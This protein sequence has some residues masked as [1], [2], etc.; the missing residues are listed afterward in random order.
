MGLPLAIEKRKLFAFSIGN[1]LANVFSLG[2]LIGA[3]SGF[4][5]LIR[6]DHSAHCAGLPG[7]SA[8]RSL[9][10]EEEPCEGLIL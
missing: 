7:Q 8:K 2:G 1:S 3:S 9:W 4:V 5:F 6:S 10:P